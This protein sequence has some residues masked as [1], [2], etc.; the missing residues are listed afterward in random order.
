MDNGSS[1][2][3]TLLSEEY[4]I[5][6]NQILYNYGQRSFCDRSEKALRGTNVSVNCV[7]GVNIHRTTHTNKHYSGEVIMGYNM[8]SNSIFQNVLNRRYSLGQRSTG[9][10]SQFSVD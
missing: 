2:R 1:H 10:H 6:M 9:D 7:E 8:N 4:I 3:T 5:M